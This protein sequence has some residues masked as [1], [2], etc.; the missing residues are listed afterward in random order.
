M[1]NKNHLTLYID[2]DLTNL[3][4]S[5]GLNLSSEFEEWIRIRLN[6]SFT[7]TP[8]DDTDFEIAKHQAEIQRLKSTA[9]IQREQ[10]DKE[11]EEVMV[12]DGVID[13]EKDVTMKVFPETK[14]EDI[15]VK[16]THGVQFLFKQKFN[17]LLNPL[18]AQ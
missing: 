11:K 16:R 15:A 1:G 6:Q 2:N 4:K 18:E 12:I 5:S 13:N 3:A 9:E 10:M 14:W 8:K 7:D 17:K